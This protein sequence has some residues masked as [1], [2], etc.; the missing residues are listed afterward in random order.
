MPVEKD[1]S[2]YFLVPAN[3][4]SYFQALD[5]NYMSVQTE[6][7]YV[8]YMPGET[9]SCIGCHETP[10]MVA[11]RPRRG[12][13]MALKRAPSAPGSQPG[14]SAGR[15]LLSFEKHVQPVLDKHCVKC[16]KAKD[17]KGG[18]VLTGEPTKLW[19]RSYE[20]LMKRRR[21]NQYFNRYENVGSAPIEY[22]PPYMLG[23]HTSLLPPILSGGRVAIR[24]EKAAAR[25]REL[26]SKHKD[27]KVT[28]PEFV[29][30]VNW[31]D[32]SCQFHP[33]Y[34][35]KKNSAYKGDPFYRPD[36][37]FE[38]AVGTEIPEK[39]VPLYTQPQAT[40][41]HKANAP[42]AKPAVSVFEKKKDVFGGL[43]SGRARVTTSTTSQW[44]R[45]GTHDRLVGGDMV[46]DFAFR[47]RSRPAT[48][49][50][51]NLI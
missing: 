34:W 29:K 45:K 5:E 47:K 40:R 3:R 36:V 32:S 43:I 39:L 44:D 37:S 14:E 16:H 38:D 15:K 9:R 6:R 2:A 18:L 22:L 10:D 33:S 48:T 12:A 21:R 50:H 41:S 8:N 27:L 23:S 51:D 20:E 31:L 30:V 35:G 1:G 49:H 24:D 17:R 7:T 25:S 4:N 26:V 11:G 28:K 13:A 19:S 46:S 42:A